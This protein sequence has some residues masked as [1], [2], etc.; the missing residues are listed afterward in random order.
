M[1]F[2]PYN[3]CHNC[4]TNSIEIYTWHNYGQKYAKVLD[5]YRLMD[6]PPES[7]DKYAIYIMRCSKCGRE[8]KMVWENNIPRPIINNFD[9]TIFMNRFKEDS[10]KG[11]PK[12]IN[13]IY[14]ERMKQ[15]E[16]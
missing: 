6:R 8:Y 12:I 10:L 3:Y 11:R 14:E 7:L 13:N 9:R 15:N 5:H 4:K 16:N 1:L 2:Y